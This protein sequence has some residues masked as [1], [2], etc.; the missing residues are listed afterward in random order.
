MRGRSGMPDQADP[1]TDTVVVAQLP[2]VGLHRDLEA[3]A[4]A[5]A[6]M[7]ELAG[8]REILSAT[9]S[10]DSEVDSCGT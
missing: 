4:P 7:A 6:A 1:W 9:A 10:F 3:G 8:L 5:R 2:D